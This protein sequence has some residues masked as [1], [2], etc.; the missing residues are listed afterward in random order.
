[1]G[2]MAEA[3]IT[4]IGAYLPG[5]PV[6]NE[7]LMTR[8]TDG[9][10]RSAR[11]GRQA[12]AANGIRTRHY[13]VDDQGRTLMLN[14]EL[15]ASA[16]RRALADRGIPAS[17]VRMLATGTTQGD[18]LVP[19]FASM[20]HGRLGG[21]PM[22]L[23]S[24][25]G[26]CASSMAAL[27]AAV[28]AVR[29]GE[30]PVALAVGSELASRSLAAGARAA[31]PACAPEPLDAGF[32]RW[33]LSDG[34]GAVVVEPEPRP[35]GLSLRVDWMHLVSHAHEHPA[36]MCAGL[37]PGTEPQPGATWLDGPGPSDQG[38][39]DQGSTGEGPTVP[40]LRQDMSALPALIDLGVAE[41]TALVAAGRIDPGTEHVLCHYS[42]EHF[43]AKLLNRL[44]AAGHDPDESR[45]FT[46]LHTAG[47]TG[48]A[49]IFVMLEAARPRLR[50]GDRVLLV[51][52]E[53]GRFSLAFAQLT[54]VGP[55]VSPGAGREPSPAELAAS[56][57]GPPAGAAAGAAG[58]A[59]AAAQRELAVVWADFQRQLSRV[60]IV[61]R[62][63]DGTATLADYRRLLLNLRQQVVDGGR[64]IS[65][66]AA[67]FS[68]EKFWL[69]SAAIQ[70]AAAEHRDFQLLEHDYAAAGG[71][72]RDMAATPAN[73]GSAALSAF[74][75]HRAGQPDPV[76]LL[77][78]MFVIE[79]LG[80]RNAAG[81]AG[82]LQHRLGLAD[83]QVSFLRYHA[84][85]DDEHFE[86]LRAA[87][88]HSGPRPTGL[89]DDAD[90]AAVARTARV[91]ARLYALQLEEL[92]HV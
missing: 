72:P 55:A 64:W 21:G 15:A 80:A 26:V 89:L 86:V 27:K 82:R 40:R 5:E 31:S 37:A 67:S 69:R 85:G 58:A 35:G 44:R 32:L 34:A 75:F 73:I 51:V 46:N 65:L 91:V 17:A 30:H 6:D 20:V 61:R 77:G 90:L 54:C 71:D 7:Q 22:E 3:Y 9:T 62:I 92:D 25:A 78:A 47:N 12:L 68:A 24:A 48:A 33:T 74:M 70:H 2:R 56:P 11:L 88:N 28:T 16:A 63:E 18:V 1:M 36:C 14:E 52:P 84:D 39:S 19:G 42:A 76:D 66:A 87:L 38:P 57:L 41:Y 83:E 59:V 23:L 29:L 81:W 13:A 50:A 45:W 79:G 60:P 49:S 10:T 8:L 43:R 53:S 4:G